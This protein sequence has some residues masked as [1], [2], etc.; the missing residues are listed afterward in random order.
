[1]ATVMAILAAKGARFLTIGPDATVLQA[2]QL[3]NEH[4]IGA[5]VV[6]EGDAMAG[7]FTEMHDATTAASLTHNAQAY[8]CG[9]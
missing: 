6:T 5:L 4:K 3:M 8:G 9:Q 2:A 1:M 7:M